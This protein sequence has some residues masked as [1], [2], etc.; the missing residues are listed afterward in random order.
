MRHG[1]KV[2]VRWCRWKVGLVLQQPGLQIQD[3]FTELVV[4]VLQRLVVLLQVTKVL[5]LLL[6]L[7]DVAFFTLTECSL[8]C[9]SGCQAMM[10]GLIRTC[11]ARFCAARLLVESSL[12]PF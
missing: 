1:V 7:L 4:L 9:V 11:A 12:F 3:V 10:V 8:E 6:E 5:D 2:D